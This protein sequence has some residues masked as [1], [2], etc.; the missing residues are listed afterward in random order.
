MIHALITLFQFSGPVRQGGPNVPP[1]APQLQGQHQGGHQDQN[2]H[3]GSR[4][5]E[6]RNQ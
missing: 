5:V 6:E 1:G 4:G 2:D 3:R